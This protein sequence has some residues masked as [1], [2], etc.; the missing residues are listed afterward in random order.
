MAPEPHVAIVGGGLCGLSLAIA[1]KK[2]STPFKIYE[3]RASFTEQGTGINLAPNAREAFRLIDEPLAPAV[4]NLSTRNPPPNEDVWMHIRL[5]APT[6]GYADGELI[7]AMMA[8]PTGST[9]VRRNDL[10]ALL[11]K[12]A[13]IENAVFNKKLVG[14]EQTDSAVLLSFADKTTA[15]AS[16]VVACDGIHSFARRLI[17]GSDHDAVSSR[18]SGHGAYRAVLPRERVADAVGLDLASTSNIFVGPG[19]YFIMYPVEGQASVNC[20]LWCNGPQQWSNREWVLPHQQEAMERSATSWGETVH[21]LLALFEDPPF[22]ATFCHTIQPATFCKDRIVLIGDAAHSMPPHLGQ[23]AAQA[24]EDAYVLAETLRVVH[25]E[26]T[27]ADVA[28]VKQALE[29]FQDV[30][31]PRFQRVLK[32]SLD[33]WDGW[34]KWH[35]EDMKKDDV[36][37]HNQKWTALFPEIWYNDISAQAQRVR[38]RMSARF[39]PQDKLFSS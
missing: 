39:T 19:G 38:D 29:A 26:S 13:G 3:A 32:G 7:E 17:L 5:G 23:G 16:V 18:Y 25:S 14:L 33:A 11:A 34:T 36:D 12:Q 4:E 31:M 20:G 35:R 10:L 22:F 1:L 21:K 30:R 27:F 9:T 28:K 24:M 6:Q 37:G 15:I 2:R 8:P